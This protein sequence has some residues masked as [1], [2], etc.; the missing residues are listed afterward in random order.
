MNASS[1]PVE[2]MFRHDLGEVGKSFAQLIELI[3]STRPVLLVSSETKLDVARLHERGY[4]S[5]HAF[6]RGL[7][8]MAPE[9]TLSKEIELGPE[10]VGRLSIFEIHCGKQASH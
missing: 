7:T 6:F 10:S 9:P 8:A 5:A 2:A 3:G 4:A 1:R